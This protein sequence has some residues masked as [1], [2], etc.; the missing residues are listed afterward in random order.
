MKNELTV[1]RKWSGLNA[2]HHFQQKEIGTGLEMQG[3]EKEDRKGSQ[4]HWFLARAL[5]FD[6]NGLYLDSIL[7]FT[8]YLCKFVNSGLN[9]L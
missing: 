7:Y 4:E 5:K 3:Q 8:Y 6:Y 9:F 2:V 1:K